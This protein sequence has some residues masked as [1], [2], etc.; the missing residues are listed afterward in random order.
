LN[1]VAQV[2]INLQAGFAKVLY[3]KDIVSPAM[4][5][6]AVTLAGNDSHHDI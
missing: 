5:I 2:D 4:L 6:S 3:D 1:G